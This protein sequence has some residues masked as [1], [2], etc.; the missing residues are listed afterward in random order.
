MSTFLLC[1]YRRA[2]SVGMNQFW[3]MCF[4]R[5]FPESARWLA[6][7]G[8]TT[9]C[10]RELRHIAKTNRTALPDN[11]MLTLQKIAAKKEKIYGPASLFS[12]WR[13]A[14]NTV[15]VVYLWWV[16]RGHRR[17]SF[18]NFIQFYSPLGWLQFQIF[19]LR[20]IWYWKIRH[21]IST[22]S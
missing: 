12:N 18:L 16:S 4:G 20:E 8:R 5:W 7:K 19:Q 14:K 1:E 22:A 9:Q 10:A 6:A 2:L 21:V 3:S 11:A 13:L 17:L 15:L